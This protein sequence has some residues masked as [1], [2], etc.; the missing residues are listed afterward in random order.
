[1]SQRIKFAFP[2]KE[3]SF[4]WLL[5][6]AQVAPSPS[7]PS[8][9]HPRPSLMHFFIA[10]EN[11]KINDQ[12]FNLPISYRGNTVIAK[13]DPYTTRVL[14]TTTLTQCYTTPHTKCFLNRLRLLYLSLSPLHLPLVR[15][16]W[17]LLST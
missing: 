3:A 13:Y 14:P 2:R 9:L 1:M 5:S 17:D 12:Q 7:L 15:L 8:P 11:Q 4:I 16:L 10:A 6:M